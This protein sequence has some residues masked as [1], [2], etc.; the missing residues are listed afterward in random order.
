MRATNKITSPRFADST[1][2][3]TPAEKKTDGNKSRHHSSH[4]AHQIDQQETHESSSDSEYAFRVHDPSES[5]PVPRVSVKINGVKGRMDADS[6]INCQPDGRRNIQQ[7][8][9]RA[10]EKTPAKT[11]I[12]KVI[13]IRTDETD[14]VGGSL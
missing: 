2:S 3:H 5:I 13:C 12:H 10:S 6:G 7:N 8:T 11:R 1:N 9:N 4:R 14:S